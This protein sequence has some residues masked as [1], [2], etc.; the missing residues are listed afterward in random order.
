MGSRVLAA[1]LVAVVFLSLAC[2]GGRFIRQ[3]EYEEDV[4]LDLDGTATVVVNASLPALVALHGLDLPLD[5]DSR[6]DRDRV[7][8]AYESAVADVQ[9]VSRSWRRAG[10]RF[11]QIRID[12]PDIRKLPSAKPF[13]WSEYSLTEA[14]G[15][16]V[17]KQVVRGEVRAAPPGV[18]WDGRELV[19]FRLHLPSRIHYHNV[20]DVE[21]NETG[22]VERG[23]ILTWE[24]RLSDRL[25]GRPLEMEARMDRQSILGRTLRLFAGAFGAALLVLGAIIWWTAR[26]GR[27][28]T[29]RSS[30]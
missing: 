6:F 13:D 17:F 25:A 29:A 10:R 4:Y 15:M 12:V 2:R 20:R 30:A 21:T 14:S 23:N 28:P 1:M 8:A 5:A 3:Y 26:R 22:D 9:R 27:Q 16:H 19:A 24:Q 18:A 11:V 7:R